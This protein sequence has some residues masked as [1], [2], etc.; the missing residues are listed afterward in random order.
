MHWAMI[1]LLYCRDTVEKCVFQI[2]GTLVD[3]NAY[4]QKSNKWKFNDTNNMKKSRG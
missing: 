3:A 2:V 4:H 1:S